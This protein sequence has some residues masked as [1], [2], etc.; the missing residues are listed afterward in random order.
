LGSILFLYHTSLLIEMTVETTEPLHL[1]LVRVFKQFDKESTGLI[2][3]SVLQDSLL[4]L[5]GFPLESKVEIAK[6]LD[7]LMIP[8]SEMVDYTHFSSWIFNEEVVAAVRSSLNANIASVPNGMQVKSKN[9]KS[10]GHLVQ[11]ANFLRSKEESMLLGVSIAFLNGG[12]LEEVRRHFGEDA[13]PNYHELN[14]TLFCSQH[15]RGYS[16]PCPRDG[17]TH[18]SY[19]DALDPV[20]TGPATVMLSW[21]WSYSARTVVTALARWCARSN[22]D[23]ATTYVWQCALCNNQ[24]RVEEKKARNECEDFEVFRD[25]FE[26]RVRSTRHILALL[27]PWDNPVY[28]TRIWCVFELW[29]ACEM[30]CT[31][32]VILSDEAEQQFRKGLAADGMSTVW[33]VFNRV[34]IQRAK[35]TVS[36]DRDN[37]LRLVDPAARTDKEYDV[38]EKVKRLNQMVVQR[39]QRW[40]TD[41]SAQYV[42]DC[43]RGGVE[44]QPRACAN[45]AWLL[46]EVSD[47]SRAMTILVAA[48]EALQ[49]AGRSG[50]IDDAWLLKSMGAWHTDQGNYAEGMELYFQAKQA[51]ES[52]GA[53]ETLEYARLTRSM[54]K[55]LMVQGHLAKAMELFQAA[56]QAF[57]ASNATKTPNYGVFLRSL[58]QCHADLG[59]IEEAAQTFCQAKL[60]FESTKSSGTPNYAGVLMD[61]GRCEMRKGN[62]REA[63][64]LFKAAE[65][66]FNAAGAHDSRNYADLMSVMGDCLDEQGNHKEALAL[67]SAAQ[68]G[69]KAAGACKTVNYADLLAN[70]SECLERQGKVDEAQALHEEA[71]SIY[72]AANAASDVLEKMSPLERGRQRATRAL[73]NT[74]QRHI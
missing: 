59:Q 45:T 14:K 1:Q 12:F 39:L 52:S 18:C 11:H 10:A 46:M 9:L 51:L 61:M 32:E 28:V 54:G 20:H 44:L 58:G 71:S 63:M 24:F 3:R 22:R 56:R 48:R 13:D 67:F 70:M 37:I 26:N 34:Q 17:K 49:A 69:F 35:A 65:R 6:M 42:E 57:I 15:S 73:Q 47:F 36:N 53:A 64:P 30:D 2:S 7:C 4:S 5:K 19:A 21:T 55:T 31:L 33:Q 62:L 41:T 66:A 43:L 68:E 25:M 23:P 38:S 40:C 50:S 8:G 29:A 60:V 27:S 74:D 72:R 16:V